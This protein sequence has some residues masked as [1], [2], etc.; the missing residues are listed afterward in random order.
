MHPITVLKIFAFFFV[1][2]IVG[3]VYYW[4]GLVPSD[5]LPLVVILAGLGAVVCITIFVRP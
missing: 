3:M 2:G 1:G 4:T 5:F